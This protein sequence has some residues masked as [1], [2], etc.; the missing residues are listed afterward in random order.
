LEQESPEYQLAN[1][2]DIIDDD[3]LKVFKALSYT[4]EEDANDYRV[5]M[6]K[7]KRY[8][9]GEVTSRTRLFQQATEQEG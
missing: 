3:G 9:I 4:E 1:S 6:R 5:V 2:K 7:M 8:C